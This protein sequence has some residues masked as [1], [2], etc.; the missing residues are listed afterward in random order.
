MQGI[1]KLR[2]SRNGHDVVTHGPC[3]DRG[4]KRA[5]SNAGNLPSRRKQPATRHPVR[6][7]VPFA[8]SAPQQRVTRGRC[9]SQRGTLLDVSDGEHR[10][11]SLSATTSLR[12]SPPR[13]A[14]IRMPLSVR[15]S[16]A[17]RF[18]TVGLQRQPQNS[19]SVMRTPQLP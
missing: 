13:P 14:A 2:Y 6:N 18:S 9:F 10:C 4:R 8:T 16:L 12:L 15:T 5:A 7:A 3:E 1:A 17:I 11:P 19:D